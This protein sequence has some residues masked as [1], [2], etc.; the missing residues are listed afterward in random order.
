MTNKRQCA[1]CGRIKPLNTDYFNQLTTGYWRGTCKACMAENTRRHYQAAPEKVVARVSKY[2][3]QKS[4]A[5]GYMTYDEMAAMRLGLATDVA[6]AER[7]SMA[8]GNLTT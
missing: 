8:E 7:R 1:K 3:K 5:G 4:T 2:K 6:T